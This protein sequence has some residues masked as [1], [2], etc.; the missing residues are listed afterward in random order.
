MEGSGNNEFIVDDAT[1]MKKA[2]RRVTLE[3]EEARN[4]LVE[5]LNEIPV[6]PRNYNDLSRIACA[7][8]PIVPV[9]VEIKEDSSSSVGRVGSSN[10]SVLL[11]CNTLRGDAIYYPPMHEYWS[12][13]DICIVGENQE[14]L[15]ARQPPGG[16]FAQL[17][18]GMSLFTCF[19]TSLN[20]TLKTGKL[21]EEGNDLV[22]YTRS[23]TCC[24]RL[25]WKLSTLHVFVDDR[26]VGQ[27]DDYLFK[28]IIRNENQEIEYVIH[29]PLYANEGYDDGVNACCFG[30]NSAKYI[31][32]STSYGHP[33]FIYKPGVPT[34]QGNECGMILHRISGIDISY[35][36]GCDVYTR[37]RLLGALFLIYK[38]HK[39]E[40][41][42]SG[43]TMVYNIT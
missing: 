42:D 35:P 41:T 43:T 4:R 26:P 17:C 23:V 24:G 1:P 7:K 14:I 8:N 30:M 9:A 38:V 32:K 12:P 10:L 36:I 2:Q 19:H 27:V 15:L 18:S 21:P 40:N 13:N 22:Q 33:Y 5:K 31:D 16:F 3:Q 6:V 20:I 34:V 37:S 25:P 28:Y 29:P 11:G 39:D